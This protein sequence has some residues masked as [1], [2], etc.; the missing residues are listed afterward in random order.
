MTSRLSP[1]ILNAQANREITVAYKAEFDLK[2][3]S[4]IFRVS[5]GFSA[6]ALRSEYS[7]G[8]GSLEEADDPN[9]SQQQ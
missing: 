4:I 1:S 9:S 3:N 8:V 2:T 7:A 6:P 5:D